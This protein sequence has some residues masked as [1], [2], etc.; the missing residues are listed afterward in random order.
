[1]GE[2][3]EVNVDPNYGRAMIY[4]GRWISNTET[5]EV[6]RL[7]EPQEPFMGLWEPVLIAGLNPSGMNKPAPTRIER[8]SADRTPS[9]PFHKESD[10]SV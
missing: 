7:V 6:W 1:M 3:G 8:G 5:G 2:A 10:K 9:R 4:G